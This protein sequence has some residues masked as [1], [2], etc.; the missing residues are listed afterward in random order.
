MAN[1]LEMA[2]IETVQ[3]LHQRSWSQRRIARVHRPIR[4]ARPASLFRCI[5]PRR[6]PGPPPAAAF[7]AWPHVA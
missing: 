7:L 1:R 6:P 5:P 3:S 2:L 4:S